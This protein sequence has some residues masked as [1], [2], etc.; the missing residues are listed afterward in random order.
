M[1]ESTAPE[2]VAHVEPAAEAAPRSQ[3]EGAR[4]N[5]N[6]NARTAD[7][8]RRIARRNGITYTEAVRRAVEVLAFLVDERDA[9]HALQIYEPER[10]VTRELITL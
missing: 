4:L 6:I 5:V 2:S 8:L 3:S 10:N 9:G 7:E 1:S